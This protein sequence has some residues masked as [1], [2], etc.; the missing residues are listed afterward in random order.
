MCEEEEEANRDKEGAL[1]EC[2]GLEGNENMFVEL[3]DFECST[4]DLD[5]L[6]NDDLSDSGESG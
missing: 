2:P 3:D 1:Y 6:F 5:E 4:A